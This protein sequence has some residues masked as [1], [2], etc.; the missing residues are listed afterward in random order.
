MKLDLR[1]KDEV[2]VVNAKGE[3]EHGIV[4]DVSPQ[5]V[6][7]SLDK[8]CIDIAFWLDDPRLSKWVSS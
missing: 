1:P 4:H 3:R 2:G 6:W 7:V 5:I 8:V